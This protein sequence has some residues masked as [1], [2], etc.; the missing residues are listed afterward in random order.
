[1]LFLF[2]QPVALLVDLGLEGC[3]VIHD[4]RLLDDQVFLLELAPVL[5]E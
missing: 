2:N 1:M 3:S 4:H 5:L